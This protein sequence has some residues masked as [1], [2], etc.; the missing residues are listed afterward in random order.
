MGIFFKKWGFSL[1]FIGVDWWSVSGDER[2]RG[3]DGSGMRENIV[4]CW[5]VL[6][7]FGLVSLD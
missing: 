4:S 5:I 6:F 3:V 2:R 7:Y 1:G